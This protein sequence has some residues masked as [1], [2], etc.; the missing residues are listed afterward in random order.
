MKRQEGGFAMTFNT[1]AAC[2][3][4][5]GAIAGL[6]CLG[7]GMSLH[8]ASADPVADF[9]RGKTV[10]L[11]VGFPPGGGY[12]ANLRVLSRH[13]G[14]FIPGQPNVVVSNMP[15]AGSLTSA[16]YLYRSAPADG[17]MMGMFASST[18][19]EP[20]LGDKSAQFDPL[21]FS[22]IGSMAQD[23]AYCGVWQAPGVA[24]DFDEMMTKET[25]FGGA[26]PTAITYQH[27]MVIKNVLG[28][29]IKV[30]SGYGGTRDVN[31]AMNR[32]EVNGTCGLFTSSIQSQWPNEVKSGQLKLVI[33]MGAKK[34]DTFGPVPSVFDY[35]KTD[36]QRAI[37]DV[38][39]GQLLLARPLTAPPGVPADRVAALQK[40][41]FNT[42]K[43]PTFLEE[44]QRSGIEVDPATADQIRALL[45]KYVALPPDIIHKALA[46]MGR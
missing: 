8:A 15:G 23:V 3:R 26:G 17:T 6:V 44:A 5:S 22:W 20:I 41:L 11:I 16:N 38:H 14:R 1:A 28:A 25:I 18:A 7:L 21:K 35:A 2:A 24:K 19:V 13:I 46:A 45:S 27:P 33:Q 30:V 32:G 39:F 9:Y 37:F 31:L 34:S 29:K 42:L 40:A 36:E 4:L 12:D 10:T 43:D